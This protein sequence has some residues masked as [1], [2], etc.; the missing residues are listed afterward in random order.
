MQHVFVDFFQKQPHGFRHIFVTKGLK[1][2]H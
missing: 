1:G 2:I